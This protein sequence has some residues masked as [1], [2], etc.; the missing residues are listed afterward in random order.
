MVFFGA[1]GD[2][3]ALKTEK[4]TINGE[5]K[6]ALLHRSNQ[7][8]IWLHLIKKI[9]KFI[10]LSKSMK[11]LRKQ[12]QAYLVGLAITE[13]SCIAWHWNAL[14]CR[15]TTENPF[16]AKKL[17]PENLFTAAQETKLEIRRS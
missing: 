13:W 10:H 7:M 3:I 12:G 9:K 1:Y 2:V 6:D 16:N 14:I 11:I 17:R 4:V 15:K 8:K 5:Q